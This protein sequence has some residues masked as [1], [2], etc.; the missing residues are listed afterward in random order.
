MEEK[1]KKKAEVQRRIEEK[2]AMQEKLAASQARRA[3]V[4]E[5]GK[6]KASVSGPAPT[7]GPTITRK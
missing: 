5:A 3:E 2:K 7:G 1:A 6:Q 4:M